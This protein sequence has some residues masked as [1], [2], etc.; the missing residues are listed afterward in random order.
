MGITTE[1]DMNE[2]FIIALGEH[3]RKLMFTGEGVGCYDNF[4]VNPEFQELTIDTYRQEMDFWMN[5]GIRG[6]HLHEILNELGGS[7]IYFYVNGPT[8]VYAAWYW[9]GDGTL[10]FD[11]YNINGEHIKIINNDCKKN[12]TWEVVK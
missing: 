2:P 1:F 4:D 9:D 6:E 12:Y 3:Y 7:S 5:M 8:R 10:A 11:I